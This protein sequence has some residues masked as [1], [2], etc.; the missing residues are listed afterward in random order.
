MVVKGLLLSFRYLI[1]N[2]KVILQYQFLLSIHQCE[3]DTKPYFARLKLNT[4]IRRCHTLM[5]T[6]EL[7]YLITTTSLNIRLKSLI[8]ATIY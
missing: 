1:L 8:V 2:F 3:P 6:L 7:R 5:A 4:D